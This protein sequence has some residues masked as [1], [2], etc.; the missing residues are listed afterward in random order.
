MKLSK[1][2]GVS[3]L[4]I[5]IILLAGM[6]F[7]PFIL[8]EIITPTSLVVWLLLRIFVL[9][10]GQQYYWAAIIFVVLFFL[11][12]LLAQDQPAILSEELLDSNATINTIGYWR[13]LF[14]LTNYDIRD[15]QTLRREL[16]RLLLSL[17]ATKQRTSADFR[18]YE[19]L[20][21]G[22]IPLP[23]RIHTFLFLDQPKES[24]RSLKKL[25]QSLEKTP[26]KWI[27]QWTGQEAAEHYRM[28]DEVLGFMETTLEMK[29][30][31]GKFNPNKH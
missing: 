17:Y 10:I 29:N 25:V 20:Q 27:R 8:N 6:L 9:S 18:L 7:W 16:I 3:I 31:N 21:R 15:E 5:A 11:Y 13:S 22:E 12:R 30:D 23:D 26:R 24:G 4:F 2:V 1:R 28:I 19:A 14:T